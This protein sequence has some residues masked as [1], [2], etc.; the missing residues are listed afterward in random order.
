MALHIIIMKIK[1]TKMKKQILL[2]L[3]VIASSCNSPKNISGSYIDLTSTH[4]G[5]RVYLELNPSHQ[6]KVSHGYND[7][8]YGT[9]ERRKDT[10]FLYAPTFRHHDP[11][12]D[13]VYRRGGILGILRYFHTKY[14]SE[15]MDSLKARDLADLKEEEYSN[16]IKDQLTDNDSM[17]IFIIRKN[18]LSILEKNGNLYH[19]NFKK[20][21]DSASIQHY[22]G[23][24]VVRDA[25]V[26]ANV[27]GFGKAVNQSCQE[28][29]VVPVFPHFFKIYIGATQVGLLGIVLQHFQY[30]ELV[31]LRNAAK[32]FPFLGF[33]VACFA[34][35]D[36]H[37]VGPCFQYLSLIVEGNV[38]VVQI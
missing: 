11:F 26:V 1:M 22:K 32:Q 4:S 29:T 36:F 15:G 13:S 14:L 24:V 27:H 23:I 12:L 28:E 37:D 6:F 18:S 9:W 31:L 2:L 20:L 19:K 35:E 17:D 10:L 21:T 8:V 3:M 30:D 34:G 16:T 33:E 25:D 38:I 7:N 5:Q